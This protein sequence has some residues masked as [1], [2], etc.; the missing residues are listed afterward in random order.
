MEFVLRGTGVNVTE[1]VR[2]ATEA[3]LGGLVKRPHPT[4]Q[5]MEVELI[6]ERGRGGGS[7]HR[8][9]VVCATPRRTFRAE[10]AGPDLGSAL[11]QVSRRLRRQLSEYRSRQVEGWQSGPGIG[12]GSLEA[13]AEAGSGEPG[14]PGAAQ[15]PEKA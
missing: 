2:R 5:R 9:R 7:G 15:A 8:V 11:D 14:P 3:K 13:E 6:D 12:K 4:V 1:P 10:G